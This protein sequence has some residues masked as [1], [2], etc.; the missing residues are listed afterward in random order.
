MNSLSFHPESFIFDIHSKTYTDE[1]KIL[2]DLLNDKNNEKSLWIAK[3]P[4]GCCGKGIKLVD[5]LS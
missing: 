1:E 3:N 4:K 5:N 2:F